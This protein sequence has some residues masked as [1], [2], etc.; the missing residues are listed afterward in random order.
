MN[1]LFLYILFLFCPLIAT[2]QNDPISKQIETGIQ[3]S[4]NLTESGKWKEAFT[5]CKELDALINI[6]ERKTKK[7]ADHLHYLVSKERLRMYKHMKKS[8]RCLSQLE[9]MKTYAQK[10]ETSNILAD[11]SLEKA[12]YYML[13][14]QTDKGIQSYKEFIYLNTKDNSEE[15]AKACYEKMIEESKKASD[16]SMTFLLTSLYTQWKDSIQISNNKLII[17]DLRNKVKQNEQTIAEKD[18][19]EKSSRNLTVSLGIL[20]II[21]AGVIGLLF[22]LLLRYIRQSKGLKNSL[23]LSSR[24]N[25]LLNDF[26]NQIQ[27]YVSPTLDAINQSTS[28]TE[29]ANHTEALQLFFQHIEEYSQLEKTK[30]EHYELKEVNINSLCTEILKQAKTSFHRDVEPVL[31]VPRV[32]IHTHT[33]ALSRILLYLL[34]NAA[35]HTTSGKISLE[36]KKRSAH[37]GQFIITDTGTGIPEEKRAGLFKPFSTDYNLTEGDGMGLPTCNLVAYKLNG[38]LRLDE[39]YRKGTRFILELHS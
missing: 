29:A 30:D 28:T 10:D 17:N 20:C 18:S 15:S 19:K 2:A 3:K 1:K 16:P 14:D 23:E 35:L 5:A 38:S 39:T 22:M 11:L 36:F 6:H 24:D 7:P 12:E 13:F 27:S 31:E 33:E 32:Y 21:F 26:I 8:D 37:S 25:E 9:Q 34:G 4:I